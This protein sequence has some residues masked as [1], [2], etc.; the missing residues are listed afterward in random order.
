MAA[1]FDVLILGGGPAGAA[2]GIELARA[3]FSVAILERSRSAQASIGD[4][5]PPETTQWLHRLDVWH[6]FNA[7]PRLSSPG[8]VSLWNTKRPAE[9]DFL[10]NPYGPGWHIDRRQFDVMM[11]ESA[12]RAGAT[13]YVGVRPRECPFAGPGKWKLVFDISGRATEIEA[14]W[15]IDATGRRRWF[16]QRQG[17]VPSTLDRLVAVIAQLPLC[18]SSDRRLFIE[19]T[20]D[21]WWYYAPVPGGRAVAAYM[22]DS[23]FVSKGEAPLREFWNHQRT[24]S[25]LA[26][27]LLANV[28]ADGPLHVCAANSSWSETVAGL[29]WIAVGDAAFSA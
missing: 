22:T 24:S 8:V 3:G 17:V 9:M 10:F 28:V 27:A 18:R 19:A 25:R 6:A 1:E 12:K 13:V 16:I 2:A 20:P 23:D 5:L 14:H 11:V 4:T 15:A 29:G 21:G 7:I 26:S